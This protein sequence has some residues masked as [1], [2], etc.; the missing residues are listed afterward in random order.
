MYLAERL[1]ICL[2]TALIMTSLRIA[3]HNGMQPIGSVS[4]CLEEAVRE[5]RLNVFGG[6]ARIL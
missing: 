6:N 3:C 2:F 5:Q 1:D 4:R